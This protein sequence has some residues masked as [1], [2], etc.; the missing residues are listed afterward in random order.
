MDLALMACCRSCREVR[1][2]EEAK[3]SG[4]KQ[5]EKSPLVASSKK[6]FIFLF[7]SCPF[8]LSGCG[9]FKGVAGGCLNL[10]NVPGHF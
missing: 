9:D 6:Y 2:A 4:R 7:F 8:C 3:M 1:M 5:F 10:R